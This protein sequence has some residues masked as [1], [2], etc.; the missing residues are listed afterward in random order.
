MVIFP[1]CVSDVNGSLVREPRVEKTKNTPQ[2]DKRHTVTELLPIGAEAPAAMGN[3][4]IRLATFDFCTWE[5]SRGLVLRRA[6]P[7]P[8]GGT[9]RPKLQASLTPVAWS[10]VYAAGAPDSLVASR[11]II[12]IE[13][14]S[15]VAFSKDYGLK[16]DPDV[17]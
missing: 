14:A 17:L 4:N 8:A 9:C 1:F 15:V 11:P 3:Q 13:R 10:S 2:S 7:L 12:A 5:R 6:E 16:S